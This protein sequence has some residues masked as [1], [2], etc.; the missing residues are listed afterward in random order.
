MA[1]DLR[2]TLRRALYDLRGGFQTRPLALA[3]ALAALGEALPAMEDRLPGLDRW[4]RAL[5]VL[6]PRD[7]ATA[8]AMLGVIAGAVMTV[9]SIILSVLLVALTLASGQF[10]P[11]LLSGF[12]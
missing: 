3:L 8:Q 1:L 7:P 6:A 4:A 2:R 10:S 11:R 9:V 5:P 12:V